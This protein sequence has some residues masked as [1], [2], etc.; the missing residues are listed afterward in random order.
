MV[1]TK[2]WG[3]CYSE[4]VKPLRVSLVEPVAYLK[5]S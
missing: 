4:T 3:G 1:L 2:P 5:S